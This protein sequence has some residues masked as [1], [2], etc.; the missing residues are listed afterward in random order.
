MDGSEGASGF[1]KEI[2]TDEMLGVLDTMTEQTDLVQAEVPPLMEC[3]LPVE[4]FE[5]VTRSMGLV[6][7]LV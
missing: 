5:V 2:G 4:P 3:P 6:P 7:K 1:S